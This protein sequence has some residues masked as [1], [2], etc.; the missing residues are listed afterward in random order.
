MRPEDREP[1]D[2][3]RE[4]IGHLAF[5]ATERLYAEQPDLWRLG[6]NGRARTL[7][8]FTHH[9]R[10]LAPLSVDHLRRHVDYSRSLFDQRGFPQQWLTD[11]WRI[12]EGVLRDELAAPVADRAVAVLRDGTG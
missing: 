9:L 7:E 8:D 12:L 6:E 4:A 10:A 5:V 2:I 3:L 1:R 11:A